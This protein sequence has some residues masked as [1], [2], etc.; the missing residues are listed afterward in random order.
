MTLSKNIGDKFNG[1]RIDVVG[2]ETVSAILC[3]QW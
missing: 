1:L 3:S 2:D